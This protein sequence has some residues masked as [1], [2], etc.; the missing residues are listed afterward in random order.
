MDVRT[1]VIVYVLSNI[2]GAAATAI[3][4]RQNRKR[5]SGIGFWLAD[6]CLQAAGA[7]LI[8]LRGRV[9]DL[10]SIVL[11]NVLIQAG[12]IIMLIGLQRFI[13]IRG[14]Q[15]HNYLLL[16]VFT[17]VYYYYGLVQP[18]LN[19]R[20]ICLSIFTTIFTF[21][22]C[23]L[24]F[25]RIAPSRRSMA[26]ATGIVFACYAAVNL[27]RA[28]ML[29]LQPGGHHDFFTSSLQDSLA[30][31]FYIVL[32]ISLTISLVLMV[33]RRLLDD[34]T[35][36]EQKFNSAFHS[37]PYA[38]MLT[39]VS[40]GK[41]FEVNESFSSITGYGSTEALGKTTLELGLWARE[42]DRREMLGS[43]I[44]DGEVHNL[45]FDF[46]RKTGEILTGLLSASR[47]NINGQD[48]IQANIGNITE[49]KQAEVQLARS[50]ERYRRILEEM[51]DVYMEVDLAGNFTFLNQAAC[52]NLGYTEEELLGHS[53]RLFTVDEEEVKQVFNAYNGVFKTGQPLTNF[54]FRVRRKDG[55]IGYAE[56]SVSLL[57][58]EKGS[59]TGFR[60][61][62]RNVTE[63]KEMEHKLLEMATHDA[64]T[65][66]PNRVLLYDRFTVAL[67]GIRRS[68]K[69]LAV[70]SLDLDNFK[71]VNDSLG[72]DT[73]DRLLS[74]A[75]G[76]LTGALRRSD[77]VARMG[78]D[79]FILLLGEIED[80]EDAVTVADKILD[81][82]RQPFTIN[83]HS[84]TV[85][86]SIGLAIH[87][88]DGET[89]EELLKR[90]DDALY[91][92][93]QG[94][95]DRFAMPSGN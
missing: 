84:L 45:E 92:A 95:R 47:L 94:G 16:A 44:R 6:M 20:E 48:C 2:I 65:G 3:I 38:I 80:G 66:L 8:L 42:E 36:Q 39:R 4:W 82:F 69:K 7:I 54:I 34:V 86:T 87:P 12:L 64:L 31:M 32:S 50:E 51:H 74:A 43:L 72:H 46:R 91:C 58:D 41:I 57:R 63:R 5:Y 88:S 77:T 71:H 89:I 93:K 27:A 60:N 52:D 75:A 30:I 19:S 78:G 90:A 35:A 9:P 85:T 68:G 53:Y 17:A 73:G 37:S 83:H 15:I 49:R 23:W 14:R 24:L 62:G 81:D 10:I 70:L 40:D 29:S 18:D 59:P 67:A 61:V 79:E 1:L 28:V 33:S 76:R 11:A 21:Q 55:T 56:T 26:L 22:C 13:G 25:R